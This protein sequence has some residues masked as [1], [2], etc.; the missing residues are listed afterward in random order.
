M[1]KFTVEVDLFLFFMD[2]HKRITKKCANFEP[3]FLFSTVAHK[4]CQDR[5]RGGGK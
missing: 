3:L 1:K 2:F 4:L 5:D